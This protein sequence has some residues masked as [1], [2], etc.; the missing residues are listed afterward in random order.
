MANIQVSLLM[1]KSPMQKR[2]NHHSTLWRC[3]LGETSPPT[4]AGPQKGFPLHLFLPVLCFYSTG[5]GDHRRWLPHT[6][7]QDWPP[8]PSSKAK[9]STGTAKQAQS[10]W[11]QQKPRQLLGPCQP[12]QHRAKEMANVPFSP[13]INWQRQKSH[14]LNEDA[15]SLFLPWKLTL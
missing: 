15:T 6:T 13:I 11:G 5:S 1:Q 2:P 4:P 12:Q 7:P 8:L 14:S 10:S 9:E 3:F